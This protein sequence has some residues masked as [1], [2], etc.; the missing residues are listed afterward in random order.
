MCYFPKYTHQINVLLLIN[1]TKK[2]IKNKQVEILEVQFISNIELFTTW[3][4]ATNQ[5]EIKKIRVLSP[6]QLADGENVKTFCIKVKDEI[7]S[8]QTEN[9]VS[10]NVS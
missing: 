4:D 2:F 8:F 10:N 1:P 7:M 9:M 5:I 6:A 3:F